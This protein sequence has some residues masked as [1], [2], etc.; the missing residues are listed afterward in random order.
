MPVKEV[1]LCHLRFY[2][3]RL[4][5]DRG[6]PP[7][8]QN[9]AYRVLVDDLTPPIKF[10]SHTNLA[11]LPFWLG[12]VRPLSLPRLRYRL[13]VSSLMILRRQEEIPFPPLC[14]T[15]SPPLP[16]QVFSTPA[17]GSFVEGAGTIVL[18][19]L[20]RARE[21]LPLDPVFYHS[22][23][24]SRNLTRRLACEVAGSISSRRLFD[25][26]LPFPCCFLIY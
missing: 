12:R 18:S 7:M 3:L 2:T 9:L 11:P 5:K 15:C 6:A 19:F 14:S 23:T 16:S 17:R 8:A 22:L 26:H 21:A 10:L 4:F 1:L 24:I 20:V 13:R 25:D